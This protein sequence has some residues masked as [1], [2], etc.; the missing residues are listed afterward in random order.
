M[1]LTMII[2]SS[3]PRAR[4]YH[5]HRDCDYDHH[6]L[7]THLRL[8]K[9]L[10]NNMSGEVKATA[11]SKQDHWH[12]Q[13]VSL[14]LRIKQGQQYSLRSLALRIKEE[15]QYSRKHSHGSK[16]EDTPWLQPSLLPSWT[17]YEL[18]VNI[19][20]GLDYLNIQKTETYLAKRCARTGVGKTHRRRRHICAI[21]QASC[22]NF[23]QC[24][25]YKQVLFLCISLHKLATWY[26]IDHFDC[27]WM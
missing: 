24:T 25:L 12:L 20:S 16:R 2:I 3:S 21:F 26:I 23:W 19:T 6:I 9:L 15:Q 11:H 18:L 17:E 22:A 5:D 10:I 13:R 1:I 4:E 14:A 27:V 8:D 7:I